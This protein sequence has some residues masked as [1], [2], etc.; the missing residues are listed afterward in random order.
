MRHALALLLL[1]VVAS[2]AAGHR[3]GAQSSPL[4]LPVQ[5]RLP[6]LLR[7]A[8][9]ATNL[10]V[11]TAS[12]LG[13]AGAD[14]VRAAALAPDGS[15]LLGGAFPGFAPAGVPVS[16]GVAGGSGGALIRLASDGRELLGITTLISPVLDIEADAA[17]RLAACGDFGLALFEVVPPAAPVAPLLR[18]KVSRC[19]I[20]LG[21]S[22]SPLA[23]ALVGTRVV[24]FTLSGSG[25]VS[26]T[27]EVQGVTAVSDLVVD[28]AN[29]QIIVTGY[30]QK[31]SDLKVA[32]IRAYRID[33]GAL[34]WTAYDFSAT[35]VK[36][37]SLAADSEGRR[38]A[39]GQDGRLY[40][41]GFTDGGNAIY[42]RSPQ[43]LA[44]TLPGTQL[45]KI[46]SYSDPFGL[47]GARSLAWLGRFDPASGALLQGQWL[48][49]RL[50]DNGGN[51]ISVKAIA[52][53][54]EGRVFVAGDSACC[55]KDRSGTAGAAQRLSVGGVAVGNY[56]GGEAF[57]LALSADLKTRL[58]WTVFAATGS[59]AGGSP[60]E[61]LA[62]GDGKVV[63]G[64]TLNPK[65]GGTRGLIGVRPVQGQV[66]SP[67][68]SEGYFVV[69]PLAQ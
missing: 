16:S 22:G 48:L 42:G 21:A 49:T 23:A 30:T 57:L 43:N 56:E 35:A 53:D 36:G 32:F 58:A 6:L 14:Q 15:I 64:A 31:A 51:S 54:A 55:I 50:S 69:W 20:G 5:A 61:A 10:D 29:G 59:S 7:P 8:N 13:G 33:G 26:G 37:A 25:V 41:A 66:A 2:L 62:V 3:A 17:G 52:A 1:I 60:A 4:P 46:D 68:A 9:P 65:A 45:V 27:I 44:Q 63:M 11:T 67:A 40:F 34:A 19:A 47:R 39:I 18:E 24:H 28:G 38:L 12:Y